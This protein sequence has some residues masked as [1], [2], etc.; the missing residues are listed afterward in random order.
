MA[1]E[2]SHFDYTLISMDRFA[3]EDPEKLARL[4]KR[5]PTAAVT[6]TYLQHLQGHWEELAKL[7][8]EERK[9]FCERLKEKK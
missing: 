7:P 5:D 4:M 1:S 3:K 6:W 2:R 9:T 8:M